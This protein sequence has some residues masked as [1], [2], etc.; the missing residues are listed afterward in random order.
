M[1]RRSASIGILTLLIALVV[2]S[3]WI[4]RRLGPNL[5]EQADVPP[6]SDGPVRS[7][8]TSVD[9]ATKM[10]QQK[11]AEAER[12]LAE[13]RAKEEA[14]KLPPRPTKEDIQERWWERP[15]SR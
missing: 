13:A 8:P 12:K 7:A 10:A 5:P 9:L 3:I 6:H 4:N 2:G 15:N 14:K 1:Q 11:K